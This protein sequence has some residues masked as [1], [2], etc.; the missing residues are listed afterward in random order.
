M[1]HIVKGVTKK[2]PP[3]FY[4]IEVVPQ[5]ATIEGGQFCW[6]LSIYANTHNEPLFVSF[7][8]QQ[9]YVICHV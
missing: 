7:R 5:N 2:S 6:S 3:F 4:C 8:G 1:R 9:L